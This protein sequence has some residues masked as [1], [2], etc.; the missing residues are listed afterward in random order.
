MK[1]LLNHKITDLDKENI[2]QFF[3]VW[4]L[5]SAVIEHNYMMHN[6]IIAFLG[7]RLGEL[8]KPDLR[9]LEVG[10]GDAHSVSQIAKHIDISHYTGIELSEM[11]LQFAEQKL[12]DFI[13]YIRLINGDMLEK[14]TE[15]NDQYDVIIAG[16]SMHHLNNQQKGHL[17]ATFKQHLNTDGILIIY[18][19]VQQE[20][21]TAKQ[22][23]ERALDN[24]ETYW[25][26]FNQQQLA[27]IRDH[28]SNN[29][30][31]ESWLGWKALAQQNGYSHQHLA[32]RDQY[33]I[34]GIMEFA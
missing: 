20:D 10:C 21:E 22:Y 25:T 2:K 17:F 26:E 15:I 19:L 24:F 29:D 8:N 31:P 23:I 30:I 14:M 6:E 32:L 5:Y 4:K 12:G 7:K 13:Q 9:I 18:D 33:N 1:P 34:Y 3:E 11:A 28:V 16:Y 27:S